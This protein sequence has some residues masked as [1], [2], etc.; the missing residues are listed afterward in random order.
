MDLQ[1]KWDSVIDIS[2]VFGRYTE[3]PD[4]PHDL[5]LLGGEPSEHKLRRDVQPSRHHAVEER[6]LH[7]LRRGNG[8]HTATQRRGQVPAGGR[9]KSELISFYSNF[10]D[11]IIYNGLSRDNINS[12]N[13]CFLILLLFLFFLL[14]WRRC[15]TGTLVATTAQPG[16]TLEFD[17]RSSFWPRPVC[18]HLLSFYPFTSSKKIC[19]LISISKLCGVRD[20]APFESVLA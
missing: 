3:V 6:T 4:Q 16:T 15:R 17:T 7:H 20:L 5:L 2:S 1:H 8:Q 13:F 9:S 14:R 11:K 19:D 10:I 12:K 18:L